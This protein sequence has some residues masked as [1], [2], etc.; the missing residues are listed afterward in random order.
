MLRSS[1]HF[2]AHEMEK[3]L[4]MTLAILWNTLPGGSSITRVL[5]NATHK[6]QTWAKLLWV[7][8]SKLN[9]KK[10]Y[11]YAVYWKFTGK[12]ITCP[13]ASVTTHS[14]DLQIQLTQ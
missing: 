8:G 9:S 4:L 6:A 3:P 12:P 11:W 10:C 14:H 2:E 1:I 5:A 13:P 7:T